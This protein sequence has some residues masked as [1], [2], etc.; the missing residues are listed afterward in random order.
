MK[1]SVVIPAHNEEKYIG[2]TLKAVLRQDYPDFEVLVVCNSCTDKTEKIA[3]TF[4]IKVLNEL[5]KGTLWARE[6]GRKEA[7]GEIIAN[8]DADCLPEKTWLS[9]GIKPFSDWR[10]SAVTGPYDYYDAPKIFRRFSLWFQKNI[11][12]LCHKMCQPLKRG[13]IIEGNVL[14]RAMA[15][16][17]I[18]GYDTSFTFYGDGTDT[19]KRI[20]AT[21]RIVFDRNLLMRTSARRLR[22]EGI[23]RI[24]FLYFFH[25]FKVSFSTTKPKNS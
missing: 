10:V 19:A 1:I 21:G 7:E 15:L 13:M 5:K 25:F 17:K 2:E 9:N 11:Y 8:V 3:R 22:E 6:R 23:S 18:Q 12:F 16:E 14:F 24:T 20:S 4:P